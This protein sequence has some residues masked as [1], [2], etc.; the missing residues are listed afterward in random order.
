MTL[1]FCREYQVLHAIIWSP[2]YTEILDILNG[3]AGDGFF[4]SNGPCIQNPP[5]S[6]L[7]AVT[8]AG[9]TEPPYQISLN[10]NPLSRTP[11]H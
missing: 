4:K 11:L 7:L 3:F 10:G 5:S 6:L 9:T 8:N 1:L 2:F